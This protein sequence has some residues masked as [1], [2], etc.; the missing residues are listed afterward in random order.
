MIQDSLNKVEEGTQLVNQSGA[1]LEEIVVAVNKAS[2]MVVEIAAASEEQAEGIQQVNKAILQLDEITQQNA[3]LVEEAAVAGDSMR[4]QVQ[5]LKEQVTFFKTDQANISDQ[6]NFQQ[7]NT[8]KG[9]SQTENRDNLVKNILEPSVKMD[10][11]WQD[12]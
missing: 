2:E 4:E 7:Q 10:K 8:M 11:E 5:S 6:A 1:T 3:A 9:L 12:F